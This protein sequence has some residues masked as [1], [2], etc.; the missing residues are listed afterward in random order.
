MK[1]CQA[2]LIKTSKDSGFAFL[3]NEPRLIVKIVF[4]TLL[5]PDVPLQLL[6]SASLLFFLF[7]C[8]QFLQSKRTLEVL[9]MRHPAIK[10]KSY[11]LL[12][13][14][15]QLLISGVQSLSEIPFVLTALPLGAADSSVTISSSTHMVLAVIVRM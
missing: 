7:L 12:T 9:L 4:R 5:S 6:H 8:Q 2:S 15:I 11:Q 14:S 13:S 3:L 1:D 10:E